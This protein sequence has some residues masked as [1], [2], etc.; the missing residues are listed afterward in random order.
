[1]RLIYLLTFA[2]DAECEDPLYKF[3]N[4]RYLQTKLEAFGIAYAHLPDLAPSKEIRALQHLADQENETAKR[5]RTELSKRLCKGISVAMCSRSYKRN[6][7]NKFYAEEM[8]V[9]ARELSVFPPEK[10]LRRVGA[11]LCGARAVRLSPIT[12]SG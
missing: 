8:L 10:P 2:R 3:A 12:A 11:V 1:M 9:R 4:S 6:P 5:K 7:E